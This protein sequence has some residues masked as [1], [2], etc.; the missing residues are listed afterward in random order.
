MAAEVDAHAV[1]AWNAETGEELWSRTVGGRVQSPPT[2]Y[3]GL[4][5]FGAA[6]GCV[7]CLRAADGALVWRFAAAPERRLVTVRNQLESAWPVPGVLVRDGTCWFAAGRSSY[8]DGGLHLYALDALTGKIKRQQVCSGRDPQT[9]KMPVETSAQQMEGLL[10][11]IPGSDGQH[12]F[13]RQRCISSDRGAAGQ[14]LFTSAGY[15]DAT[16]FNRTFWQIGS[17]R[18]TGPLVLGQ[19]VA[20]GVEPFTSRS[21]DV[22][23]QPGRH[24]YRLR[25][26]NTRPRPVTRTDRRGKRVRRSE[27][28]QIVWER[29]LG[30]RATAVVRA[31][32]T[33][34]AAGSP[35]VVDAD[36]PHGAWEGRLGGRLA[37]FRVADGAPISE[38]ALPAPPVWDGLAVARGRVFAALQDGTIVCLQSRGQAPGT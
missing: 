28:A 19:G 18:T 9:G 26:L 13:I 4:A 37:T 2:L 29:R 27:T 17:V 15:L 7:Y 3:R 11:D 14:H 16:W 24:A 5:I 10:N 20:Y 21:R 34:V 1:V 22:V 25:C 6:D 38:I 33:L 32:D 23:M 8:L 30:I 31:G 12:V 35:D 36:D